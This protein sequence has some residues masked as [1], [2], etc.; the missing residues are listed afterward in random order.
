MS[1]DTRAVGCLY[2]IKTTTT[3]KTEK[4]ERSVEHLDIV[5]RNDE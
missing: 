1:E 4:T 5:N 2:L 3:L